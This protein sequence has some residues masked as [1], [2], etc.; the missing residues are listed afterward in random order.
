M[1]R[2]T[3]LSIVT[4]TML[5][6]STAYAKQD[7]CHALA[8]SGGGNKGAY[9]AGVVYQLAHSLPADEVTWDVV[10]GVSAGALN[11]A[12]ISIFAVGDEIKMSEWLLG[13]WT[14]LETE[15]VWTMWDEGFIWGF[16][17]ASGIFDDTP[18]F[19]LLT[20]IFG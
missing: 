8:L 3:S 6:S 11:A 16:M 1:N 18:L 14:S 10:S 20:E 4:L 5:L 17:N 12:G 15:N 9:E 19:N 13:L 7:I 2:I